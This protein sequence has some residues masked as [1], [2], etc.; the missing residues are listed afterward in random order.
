MANI[1]MMQF[2]Q[3]FKRC[4]RKQCFC[5]TD[6]QQKCSQVKNPWRELFYEMQRYKNCYNGTPI[7]YA[8]RETLTAT[9]H[10]HSAHQLKKK[11][12]EKGTKK[13]KRKP[14]DCAGSRINLPQHKNNKS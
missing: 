3:H 12:Q 11:H 4:G 1:F 5:L 7:L 10:K 8:P 13:L 14:Q 9:Q 6:L 2:M